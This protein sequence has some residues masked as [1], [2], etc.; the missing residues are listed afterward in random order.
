MSDQINKK[1]EDKEAKRQE[2]VAEAAAVLAGENKI[3]KEEKSQL[4]GGAKPRKKKKIRFQVQKG[5]IFI[6]STYN[7]TAV[8]MTDT[9]GNLLAW[10]TSGL[11]GFKGAKKA[12]TYAASQVALD[13]HEK[14]QRFGLKDVEVY[15]QGVGSGRESALRTLAQK[16]YNIIA[17]KDRT[18][19][20]H[21]GCRPRKP[22]R[23]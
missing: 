6:R 5:K 13:A 8:S 17:I 14:V 9:H 15:V 10:S 11:L 18:P 1:V 21:N 19:I 20:P 23:V 2:E 3:D 7:N 22:R 12:T 4:D 16:G